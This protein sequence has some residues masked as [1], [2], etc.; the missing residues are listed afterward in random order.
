MNAL[1]IEET[2]CTTRKK[3]TIKSRVIFNLYINTNL[4]LIKYNVVSSDKET[5][6]SSLF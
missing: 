5:V 6:R 3:A 4:I 2:I 1:I